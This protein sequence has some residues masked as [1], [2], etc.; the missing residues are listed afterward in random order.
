M[1]PEE[2][3]TQDIKSFLARVWNSHSAAR[4]TLIVG[5]GLV[6]MSAA[7]TVVVSCYPAREVEPGLPPVNLGFDR[8]PTVRARLA[9]GT[10]SYTVAAGSTGTWTISNTGRTLMQGSGPW[11]VSASPGGVQVGDRTV[12]DSPVVLE[13]TSDTV[14]FEGTTYR[15]KLL[16]RPDGADVVVINSLPIADYLTGVVSAEMPTSWPQDALAAQAVAARTFLLKRIQGRR[17]DTWNVKAIELAYKGTSTEA[18]SA[19]RAVEQTEGVV[20][21]YRNKLFTAYFH[22]TCGGATTPVSKV[23][24]EEDIPPLAGVKCN[25]CRESSVYAWEATFDA[26]EISSALSARGVRS[27][28]SIRAEGRGADGHAQDI[29]VNG[30][31]RMGANEFR[32]A[33]GARKLKSTN[34]TVE[35]NGDTFHF[36]GHGWGHGV[37]LCQWGTR[38]QA[39]VGLGWKQILRHYYPSAQLHEAY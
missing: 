13:S 28:S 24:G 26:S 12:F 38:G 27:V 34:F 14:E 36:E 18:A 4:R 17:G 5:I 29:V 20:M 2:Q 11:T 10:D 30:T 9:Q 6:I 31:K 39:R 16:V 8:A 3:E 37:G 15:G 21:T 1:A 33:V 35:K 19:R 32:L 23:F 25:W 22:S 7:L